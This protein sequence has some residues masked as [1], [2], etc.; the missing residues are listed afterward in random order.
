M[1][2][3]DRKGTKRYY[4]ILVQNESKPQ[5]CI[6]W[7][8]ALSHNINWYTTFGTQKI[9]EVKLKWFQICLVHMILTTN[10]TLKRIKVINEVCAFCNAHNKNIPHLFWRC[11]IVQHFWSM[12]ETFPNEKRITGC[13]KYETER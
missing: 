10:G 3:R 1:C 8:S 4:D 5:F 6:K 12:F 2:I 13:D 11:N 9:H 7:N